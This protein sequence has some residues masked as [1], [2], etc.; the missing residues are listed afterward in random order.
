MSVVSW[1]VVWGP[2]SPTGLCLGAWGPVI[3]V[4]HF[5]HEDVAVEAIAGIGHVPDSGAW[6][7]KTTPW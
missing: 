4:Y 7:I 6:L 1:T 5:W 2:R 3:P